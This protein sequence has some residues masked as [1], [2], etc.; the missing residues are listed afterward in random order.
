MLSILCQSSSSRSATLLC[1]HYGGPQRM[2]GFGFLKCSSPSIATPSPSL[3]AQESGLR[4][5]PRQ[6]SPFSCKTAPFPPVRYE[7]VASMRCA[8]FDTVHLSP[9]SVDALV[10]TQYIGCA[11]YFAS[12]YTN[13]VYGPGDSPVSELLGIYKL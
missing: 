8:A 5:P 4:S 6:C 10:L 2:G 7:H 9:P 1:R 12:A 3:G 11:V 13:T